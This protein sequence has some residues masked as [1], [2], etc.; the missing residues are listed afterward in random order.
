MLVKSFRKVR[1][2]LA[3]NDAF[4]RNE[5]HRMRTHDMAGVCDDIQACRETLR[6]QHSLPR[7][8]ASEANAVAGKAAINERQGPGQGPSSRMAGLPD[9]D[10]FPWRHC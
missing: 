4:Y 10:V 5:I 7:D 9:G 6:N 8:L 2:R 1:L 3:E